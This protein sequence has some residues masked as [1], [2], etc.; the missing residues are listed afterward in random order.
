MVCIGSNDER[1]YLAYW[2]LNKPSI[3][4]LAE[5]VLPGV[6][7]VTSRAMQ[8]IKVCRF[9]TGG[10]VVTVAVVNASSLVINSLLTFNLQLVYH[11][12]I[13]YAETVPDHLPLELKI[14]KA[15]GVSI[16]GKIRNCSSSDGAIVDRVYATIVDFPA[17][18]KEIDT[19][20]AYFDELQSTLG[21]F[22]SE[23][24]DGPHSSVADQPSVPVTDQKLSLDLESRITR[25]SSNSSQTLCG[26]KFTAAGVTPLSGY[27]LPPTDFEPK[28][29][30]ISDLFP[31][32]K[33]ASS[34]TDSGIQVVHLKALSYPWD[35]SSK[36]ELF[37]I[38]TKDT[39]CL[40]AVVSGD[41]SITALKP[42]QRVLY[43]SN[44]RGDSVRTVEIRQ[45]GQ[46]YFVHIPTNS[47]ETKDTREN[48]RTTLIGHHFTP[49]D[50]EYDLTILKASH[51]IAHPAV[52]FTASFAAYFQPGILDAGQ[53]V[54]IG[55]RNRGAYIKP[56]L[57]AWLRYHH[58][59]F[60]SPIFPSVEP[61][62][63]TEKLRHSSPIIYDDPIYD[64]HQLLFA[65]GLHGAAMCDIK[66]SQSV[67]VDEFLRQL[68][69][70]DKLVR[71][72]GRSISEAL[73]HVCRAR[74]A[75]A[76]QFMRYL[77]LL[78]LYS[79]ES[80]FSDKD[81]SPMW[82]N[83]SV[84]VSD[85]T[86]SKKQWGTTFVH[87]KGYI[88]GITLPRMLYKRFFTRRVSLKANETQSTLAL[89]C[90]CR[91]EYHKMPNE[92]SSKLY[93]RYLHFGV[94]VYDM[95]NSAL[96]DEIS[97]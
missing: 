70:S 65:S 86:P 42:L 59:R 57:F 34:S 15:S 54:D 43:V 41:K 16:V 13:N 85:N 12:V 36:V 9:S 93:D 77:T 74:P 21:T 62:E 32:L 89:E 71:I 38:R 4:P 78:N 84:D 92:I 56:K 1:F 37:A 35:N 46:Y 66:Q 30:R 25:A 79:S 53:I 52:A 6:E 10:T 5:V 80:T 88:I 3:Q 18:R 61:Q 23:S 90:F 82:N 67:L 2:D 19:I 69:K 17:A 96:E 50:A 55:H 76:L 87:S 81:I 40:N 58:Q 63:L 64:D 39:L 11:N 48:S 73:P 26:W 97:Q 94:G 24:R 72:N 91:Y 45:R 28:P 22:K 31:E 68:Y 7:P 27:V 44:V 95:F 29:H 49:S 83:E 33:S 60:C 14:D 8:H 75:G 47:L 51:Y 20:E